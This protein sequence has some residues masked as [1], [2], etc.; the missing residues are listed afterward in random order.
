[1]LEKIN[2]LK[3]QIAAL[4]ATNAEAIE[5]LR[6]KYLSKKG[7]VSALFND[8]RTV[9]SEQK[10]EIGQKLNELKTLATERINALRDALASTDTVEADIDLTRTSSPIEV[11]T[12][13]PLS[14]VR[15]EIIDIFSR[16]GFT[17]AEGPEVEDDWHVFGALNFA[18]DHPARD[19]QD[20]FFIQRNPDVLLRTHTSSVQS[21][22]MEHAQPPIRIICPGRVYRN[23]AISYRAHCFFHQIE[24]LYVDKNVSF[25][26]LKQALLYFAREMFGPETKIR[27]RP[28]YFPFTEP[29]AEMDISCDLCGGKGCNFCKHTGWVEILGCGMV[30]PNVLESCGIDRKVYSGYALGMGVERIANLK[31]RVKDLRMFSEND[32]RF[33]EEFK[34][35]H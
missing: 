28:S 14:L 33:L 32:V 18:E 9:P 16:L 19:M 8:F 31:Y 6:I 15:Q 24:A 4:T 20:T 10:R 23:E 11:G 30:D 2:T 22:V 13:H 26:D 35:A 27:L 34:S 12:R 5:A 17:V 21:R 7:E 1:M 3:E 29:S 25:T